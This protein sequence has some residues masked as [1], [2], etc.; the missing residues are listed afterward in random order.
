MSV[1]LGMHSQQMATGPANGDTCIV[2]SAAYLWQVNL[3]NFPVLILS[4]N[5]HLLDAS[6]SAYRK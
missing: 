3:W 4:T 1:C 2:P 6:I 5:V